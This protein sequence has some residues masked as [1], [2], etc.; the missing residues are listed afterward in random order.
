MKNRTVLKYLRAY[1]PDS[2]KNCEFQIS[3][4]LIILT[5]NIITI[6]SANYLPFY[7]FSLSLSL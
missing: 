3:I 4:F 7:P 5:F 6:K 1:S 2:Q